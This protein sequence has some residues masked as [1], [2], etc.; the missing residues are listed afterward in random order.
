VGTKSYKGRVRN[1]V[2]IRSRSLEDETRASFPTIVLVD[3]AAKDTLHNAGGA[4]SLFTSASAPS[5]IL[6]RMTYADALPLYGLRQ[7]I[8]TDP[9]NR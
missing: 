3:P 9:Q 5:I 2:R 4:A 6:G 8:L 1:A 7:N